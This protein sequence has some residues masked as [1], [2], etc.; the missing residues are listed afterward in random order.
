MTLNFTK[1]K[2]IPGVTRQGSLYFGR[3]NVDQ[4]HCPVITSCC[5]NVTSWAESDA[6]DCA[7][8]VQWPLDFERLGIVDANHRV[9]PPRCQP[10]PAGAPCH[11]SHKEVGVSLHGGLKLLAL[12]V[13]HVDVASLVTNGK[14]VAIWRVAQAEDTVVNLQLA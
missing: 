11:G 4:L 8:D 14:H 12:G 7:I 2:K 10:L 3:C 5:D 6:P 1:S 13:E 9:L